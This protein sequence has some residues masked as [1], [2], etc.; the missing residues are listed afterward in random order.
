[1]ATLK[2]YG[3]ASGRLDVDTGTGAL[4]K[5]GFDQ[6]VRIGVGQGAGDF[7]RPAGQALFRIGND[8]FHG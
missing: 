7:A 4:L 1:M 3:E 6:V 5:N 2:R 8:A